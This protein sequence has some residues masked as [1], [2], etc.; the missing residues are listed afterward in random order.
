MARSRRFP[1]FL[2]PTNLLLALIL[3]GA[4]LKFASRFLPA[5]QPNRLSTEYGAYV[6]EASTHTIDWRRFSS[7]AFQDARREDRPIFLEIGSLFSRRSRALTHG[8]F[9]D[10]DLVRLLNEHFICIRADISELPGLAKV[11]NLNRPL[12]TEGE[13]ALILILEPEGRVFAQTVFLP[14]YSSSRARGLYDWTTTQ[15]RRWVQE[16]EDVL[17]DATRRMRLDRTTASAVVLPGNLT[18]M[19]VQS[20][21]GALA[22]SMNAHPGALMDSSGNEYPISVAAPVPALLLDAPVA[23]APG[24]AEALLLS[25]RE[26]SCYDQA[27]GGFFAGALEPR[28]IRPQYGKPSGASALLAAEYARAANR[29]GSALFR[30]TARQTAEWLLRELIDPKS[31][32]VMAGTGTDE[33][34]LDE[35]AFYDWESGGL[36]ALVTEWMT[37]VRRAGGTGP[38]RLHPTDARGDAHSEERAEALDQ[39]SRL[40]RATRAEREAPPVDSGVYAEING[41]AIAS[42]FVIGVQLDD[43]S[44]L[45]NARSLY[46]AAVRVFVQPTGSVLHAPEGLARTTGYCGDYMGMVRAAI[47]NFRATGDEE[48]L[49]DALR[50][51]NRAME[52]FGTPSGGFL[53]SL[54]P[55]FEFAQFVQPV[56]HIADDPNESINALAARNL[57]DLALLLN[58]DRLRQA[59]GRTLRGF[60]GALELIGVHGAGYVR[61]WL[62]YYLPAVLVKGPGALT[63]AAELQRRYPHL[64]CSP[65]PEMEGA[66]L[67]GRPDGVYLATD[68]RYDGPLTDEELS[69]Q[70]S[71]IYPD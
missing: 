22:R 49:K 53:T 43:Q 69:R 28:W 47:E 40:L 68:L 9:E 18:R 38:L 34:I 57:C 54:R 32:L 7:E 3:A 11:V 46:R 65:A 67:D 24:A 25:L 5:P 17:A 33:G 59:C 66:A 70:V 52:L 42:L 63:R 30:Q 36:P 12:L 2:V 48:A 16:S 10:S 21:A 14:L 15:A 31:G 61:A 45:R 20:Y 37:V 44:L 26:S 19:D 71:R 64:V 60:A 35:S 4:G 55:Q 27:A 39:V 41:Q 6:R 51:M 1:S 29:F 58:D 56:P 50:I 8:H 23:G 62:R 13:S